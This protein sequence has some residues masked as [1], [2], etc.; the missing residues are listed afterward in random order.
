MNERDLKLAGAAIKLGIFTLVSLVVTG[1]LAMIMGKISFDAK[2]EYVVEFAN[3][4]QVEAGDDVRVAGVS[5][6]SVTDVEIRDR[7]RAAVKIKVDADVPVTS[8]SGVEIRYLNLVGARYLAVVEGQP[9]GKRLSS[10]ATIGENRTKPALNLSE[11][12][13]GFQPLFQALSPDQVNELS[14]NLIQVLQG[15]GGTVA[16]LLSHTASL[17]ESL[18][19][20]DQL[21]SRVITNLTDTLE[22]VDSRR[23]E[24]GDLLVQLN[25]WMGDLARDRAAIGES[26]ASVATMTEA[27]ANLLTDVRPHLAK[28]IAE[29]RRIMKI[30]NKP[31]NREVLAE[32]MER[33]PTTLRRQA[34]IG[35]FGSWYN[36]YL[37]DFFGNITLPSLGPLDDT[38]AVALLQEQLS[39][40]AVYST[41]ERCDP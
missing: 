25:N 40:L 29:L 31:A 33:L 7:S 15:E 4:S 39:N 18:A 20:R 8:N 11:L 22:T 17:T 21:I 9:G 12:F 32:T 13:A 1:A 5:V 38:P 35:T 2:H 14:L 16:S 24:L 10:G 3:A 6:G 34:R 37:C 41:S 19:D 28:D 36:Y 30:L 23:S 27:L 26:V